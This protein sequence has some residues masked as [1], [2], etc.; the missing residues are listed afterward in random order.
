MLVFH[1]LIIKSSKFRYF[2]TPKKKRK[3]V[4]KRK[5]T[6][7]DGYSNEPLKD[8]QLIDVKILI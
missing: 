4:Y 5:G 8:N 6:V 7:F 1:K 3:Y 2:I